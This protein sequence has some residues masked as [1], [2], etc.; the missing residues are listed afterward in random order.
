MECAGK[1]VFERR[2][3]FI[4]LKVFLECWTFRNSGEISER[5]M[6]AG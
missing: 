3:E 6:T 5:T 4:T 2:W 1:K